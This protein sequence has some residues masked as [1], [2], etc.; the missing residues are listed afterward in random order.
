MGE[1]LGDVRVMLVDDNP[2]MRSIISTILIGVGVKQI[3]EFEDGSGA[4]AA[5]RDWSADIAFVDYQMA[6]MDGLEFTRLV[7]D[8]QTSAAPYLPI[9]MVTGK[10]DRRSV[11]QAR[12]SGVTEFIVKPV[13]PRAV[14][15]RFNAVLF[16]PRSFV[17]T[18]TYFGPTRRRVKAA[19]GAPRR[20]A[21]DTPFEV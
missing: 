5:L 19:A 18:E 20:R 3:R 15:D 2:H 7:R 14:I 9:V 21:T 8:P 4:L 12:D 16:K 13:T 17:R 11:A 6:P 1:G 10:V